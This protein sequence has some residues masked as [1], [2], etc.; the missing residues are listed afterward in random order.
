[1]YAFVGNMP[2]SYWDF[3]GLEFKAN[4]NEGTLADGNLPNGWYGETSRPKPTAKGK[5]EVVIE[6]VVKASK[7]TYKVYIKKSKKFDVTVDSYVATDQT[8]KVYTAAGLG[9]I[10]GHEQR[11]VDVYSKAYDTYLKVFEGA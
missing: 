7:K 10:R 11:R 3:L 6:C 9:A 1:M 4:Q 8:G 2:L 5:N